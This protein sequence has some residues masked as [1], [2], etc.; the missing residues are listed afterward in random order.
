M[1]L[2]PGNV[3]A[4]IATGDYLAQAGKLAE[5]ADAYGAAM[6][7][8][9]SDSRPLF[10]LSDVLLRRRDVTGAIDALRRAYELD[11][12]DEGVRLL[13]SARTENDLDTAKIGVARSR[14]AEVEEMS[15]KRY[16]SPLDVAR[17]NAQAGEREKA[18]AS[19]E[20]AFKERSPGL[21]LLRVDR[22]WDRIREDPRFTDLVRR[23]GIP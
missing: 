13:A 2:D 9:P 21:V 22:A 6:K 11:G 4:M 15:R 10:G 18:F 19:L 23:V 8:E 17:L 14:L 1:R 3:A 5:A 16:V 20:A 12:E 7:A